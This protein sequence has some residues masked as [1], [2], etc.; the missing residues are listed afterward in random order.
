MNAAVRIVLLVLLGW[1][2][3]VGLAVIVVKVAAIGGDALV[4]LGAV[5]VV[6]AATR[7]WHK[8]MR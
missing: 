1:A 6:A 2:T 7:M 8:L 4:L 5:G 3:L